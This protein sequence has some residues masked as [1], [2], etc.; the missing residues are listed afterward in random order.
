MSTFDV[1]VTLTIEAED[2]ELALARI[3]DNITGMS[4][5]PIQDVSF[6]KVAEVQ[7]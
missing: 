3:A 1:T 2:A 5:H 6:E 4:R 7:A